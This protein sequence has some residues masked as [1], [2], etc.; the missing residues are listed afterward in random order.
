M[1]PETSLAILFDIAI[2]AEYHKSYNNI[3][4]RTTDYGGEKILEIY[5]YGT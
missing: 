4:R 3:E 2:F 5:L 1:Q